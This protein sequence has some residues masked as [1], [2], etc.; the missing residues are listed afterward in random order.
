MSTGVSRRGFVVGGFALAAATQLERVAH[1]LGVPVQ[2]LQACQLMPEQEIG[3]YYIADEMIR[4]DIT[5]GRPGVPLDLRLVLVDARS[6]APLAGAAVDIWHCDAMGLY[7]G[8]TA[9][10]PGDGPGGGRPGGPPPG[11]DPA[12]GG[13]PP[14]FPGRPGGPPPG[15]GRGGNGGDGQMNTPTDAQ[16]FLRGIQM[17]DKDGLA[18]FK[19]VF[20]GYY[21]GRTNHIHFKVRIGGQAQGRTYAAGHT[22]HVGQVFF[23]EEINA[24]LMQL[25]PYSLHRIHRTTNAEDGIFTGQNGRLSIAKIEATAGTLAS[26]GRASLVAAVDPTAT[27]SPVGPG[28]RGGR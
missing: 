10:N 14:G 2:Q 3:P 19:T 20:P 1:A 11:F 12:R 25:E 17:T 27:P 23:T 8:F 28:G 22:S 15:G 9:S 24:Q 18:S 7:S 13:P 16:T 5:E 21:M 4:S 6:C 26:G